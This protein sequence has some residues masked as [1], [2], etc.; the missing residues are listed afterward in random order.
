M[1]EQSKQSLDEAFE[2]WWYNEGSG[3]IPLPGNDYEEHGYR[4]SRIA[5]HNGAYVALNALG[6]RKAALTVLDH[7]SDRLDAVQENMLRRVL[8]QLPD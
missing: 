2:S 8:E 4:I 6:S 3:I 1:T 5:W 7:V